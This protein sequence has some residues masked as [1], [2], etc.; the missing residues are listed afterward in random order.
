MNILVEVESNFEYVLWSV[1][2]EKQNQDTM[3]CRE[4]QNQE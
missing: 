2:E 3:L 1:G 4:E